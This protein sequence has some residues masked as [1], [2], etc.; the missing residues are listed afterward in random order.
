MFVISVVLS[1]EVTGSLRSGRTIGSDKIEI[2]NR[3]GGTLSL[4][5]GLRIIGSLGLML[6]IYD[7]YDDIFMTTDIGSS[8]D[9]F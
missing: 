9:P 8:T 3:S 2:G 5:I 6:Y 4:F 7:I 1:L